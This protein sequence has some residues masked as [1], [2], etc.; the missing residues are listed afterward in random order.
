MIYIAWFVF[1]YAVLRFII[2]LV[3]YVSPLYLKQ[4]KDITEVKLS[5]LIPARN[6][7][8]NLP[9]LLKEISQ[10][11]Y[12][13]FEIIV[14]NDQS[15]DDT[16]S[17]LEEAQ[18]QYQNLKVIHAEGLPEGWAGK[19]HA[20]YQLAQNASGDYL[21]FLDA[22]VKVQGNLFMNAVSRM[23][24]DDLKLL[25][26]FPQQEMCTLGEKITVPI[27]NWILLSLLPLVLVQKSKRKSLAAAN[28]Q[29]MLFEAEIYKKHQWHQQLKNSLVEDIECIRLMKDNGFKVATLMGNND[30]VC[31]MYSSYEEGINGFAKNFIQ[32]YGNS[33]FVA[34]LNTLIIDLGILFIY[35]AL[36]IEQF[37]AYIVIVL[38]IR[39]LISKKSNQN[40]IVNLVLHP[41]QMTTLLIILFKGIKVKIKKEYQWKGRKI[42]Q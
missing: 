41:L 17:V 38:I 1:G 28:G 21:L 12:P 23:K 37:V 9:R 2:T 7:A 3:N 16:A 34:I 5:V 35:F 40:T 11:N 15:E 22:D 13:K 29:F 18:K 10:Q 4:A 42:A 32:F 6:E 36:N 24:K 39:M 8:H 14:Y 20:C 27:M 30:V 33:I 26:I 31:R 25:S 19:N